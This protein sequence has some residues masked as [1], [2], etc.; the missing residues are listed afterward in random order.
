M[1]SAEL[2]VLALS[3]LAIAGVVW[4]FFFFSDKPKAVSVAT[5]SMQTLKVTVRGGYD[6]SILE[7]VAGKP[8]RIEF[9]RDETNP[10]SETVVFGDF[11]VS[12]QLSPHK[13]TIV[14]F[15]PEKAGKYSFEC[16]MGMLHGS[17]VVKEPNSE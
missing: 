7:V 5:G 16:G 14:E 11:G 9:F 1:D 17:L 12:T 3:A 13:T 4:W 15:T 2:I 8:V 10:C 6:P